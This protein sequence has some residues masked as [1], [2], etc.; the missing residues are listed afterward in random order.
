MDLLE[1]TFVR[2]WENVLCIARD[3]GIRRLLLGAWGCGAFGGDP[4]MASATA[5]RAIHRFGSTLDAIVF[6][7][8][9]AGRRSQANLDAFQDS[10]PHS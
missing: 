8:P 5:K 3:Q 2:R 4:K 9:G 7:I 1:S 10:F 6:A